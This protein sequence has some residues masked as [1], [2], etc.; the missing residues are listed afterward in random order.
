MSIL[1]ND[2]P[3]CTAINYAKDLG[4]EKVIEI[5][6]VAQI[7]EYGIYNDKLVSDE[8]NF[9]SLEKD[10]PDKIIG[11]LN[12]SDT[13]Y[14][15]LDILKENIVGV[16]EGLAIA[17]FATDTDNIEIAIPTED[18]VL[19][20]KILAMGKDCGVDVTVT[21]GIVDVRAARNSII[22]HIETAA[23]IS[24]LFGNVDNYKKTTV[25]A[26][27]EADKTIGKSM[28]IPY[29]KTI[30][31]IISPLEKDNIKAISIGT[32]VYAESAVDLMIDEN[33]PLENGVITV[34]DKKCCMADQSE[35]ALSKVL[36][37]GCGKCTFCR[38]GTIQIHTRMKDITQG[39]GE[40]TDIAMIN[41]IG[42]AM[43]FS[44][45]CSMG[46]TGANF[47]L[48]SLELFGEEIDAHIRKKRCPSEVCS[49]FM[50][51]YIDPSV[52]DGCG[53]CID[54]CPVDCIDG[55][56]KYIHMIDEFDCTKCGKC[57][58]VCPTNAVVRTTGRLPK[59][60][61]RLTRVGR[62]NRR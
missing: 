50:N 18:S 42:S 55:K 5:V 15:L 56:A 38:E 31:E 20:D 30:A 47:A 7:K 23:S 33:F 19:A 8:W 49:A 44:S 61:Q 54:V 3:P 29:G 6:K 2:I 45:M 24:A 39:K 32:K 35:K 36:I 41:E 62:F 43:S 22:H 9:E 34:F 57:S 48:T 10:K 1:K 53:D 28:E 16:I 26:V 46:Q 51:I 11:A 40:T 13:E 25:V 21:F 58:E 27:K 12:N 17:A 4:K 59:L 52:C 37:N 60:P 14:M